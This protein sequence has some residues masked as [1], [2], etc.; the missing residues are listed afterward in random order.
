MQSPATR[1]P[2]MFNNGSVFYVINGTYI[3]RDHSDS[4]EYELHKCPQI[5]KS[6]HKIFILKFGLILWT[7][8]AIAGLRLARPRGIVGHKHG[9]PTDLHWCKSVTSR[10]QGPNRPPLVQ[11]RYVTNTGS[12]PTSFG[13]KRYF[14]NTG[15]QPTSFGAKTLRHEHGAPTGPRWCKNVTWQTTDL[16]D[17]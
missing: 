14:T 11:K 6:S 12:Q 7:N 16:L 1:W 15:P 9:A 17:V 13:A 4:P 8:W 10:T 2:M 5:Y 3:G